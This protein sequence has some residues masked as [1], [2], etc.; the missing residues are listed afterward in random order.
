MNMLSGY[1]RDVFKYITGEYS[2]SE[3]FRQLLRQYDL[4]R[5]DGD[6]IRDNLFAYD[7]VIPEDENENIIY[8]IWAF[9]E[10]KRLFVN[11]FKKKFPSREMDLKYLNAYKVT[12]KFLNERQEVFKVNSILKE[13][14]GKDKLACEY[15]NDLSQYNLLSSYFEI[16][17]KFLSTPLKVYENAGSVREY[18]LDY[19]KEISRKDELDSD[20]PKTI[21]E[22]TDFIIRNS[23][24]DFIDF[25]CNHDEFNKED[26]ESINMM[27]FISH[28]FNIE[29]KPDL[30]MECF[31]SKYNDLTYTY[32]IE[33]YDYEKDDVIKYLGDD[34]R[35]KNAVTIDLNYEDI[36]NYRFGALSSLR[37]DGLIILNELREKIL[38]DYDNIIKTDF[39]DT[40]MKSEYSY[41]IIDEI[42]EYSLNYL[43]KTFAKEKYD[44]LI[45]YYNLSKKDGMEIKS[46]C[47][48]YCFEYPD[49]DSKLI[50]DFQIIREFNRE[51]RSK[52]NF[53]V[54]DEK[55]ALDKFYDYS[56]YLKLDA[57]TKDYQIR[58]YF[59]H[60]LKND[61]LA[62]FLYDEMRQRDL[63]DYWDCISLY[64]NASSLTSKQK[65]IE[66]LD[67]F[68]RLYD[69]S[70]PQSLLE[71]SRYLVENTSREFIDKVYNSNRD[72]VTGLH[73]TLGMWIRN[74]FGIND[75]SNTK[76]LYDIH[77]SQ[78]H[79]LSL[80]ADDD[81]AVILKEFYDYVQ[82]NYDD[83]IE[84]VEFKN[85]IDMGKYL[86]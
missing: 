50:R 5:K 37:F 58:T 44:E 32:R 7:M 16:T 17:L 34:E 39:K 74:E 28:Y 83:I 27:N 63:M 85:T 65:I 20:S 47:Y 78:Y 81:S 62:E 30:M 35:D 64:E 42:D 29:N 4:T 6:V 86:L 41:Y 18:V 75:R 19:L 82:R 38:N 33:N 26:D 14:M 79:V 10:F 54:D 45:K 56:N 66:Y 72:Y 60:N 9:E 2:V 51:F 84:N 24:K 3:D 13:Y 25:I 21:E 59:K 68:V 40:L 52:Y 49:Y 53:L 36:S 73:F 15:L 76:L 11:Y 48:L 61:E 23:N 55:R 46:E 8:E 22:V 70:R 12:E 57:L 31:N 80:W 67:D 1:L 43:E 77:K 69:F 71:S